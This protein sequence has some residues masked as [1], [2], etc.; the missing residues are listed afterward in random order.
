MFQDLHHYPREMKLIH[1]SVTVPTLPKAPG[2][3]EENCIVYRTVLCLQLA[4]PLTLHW[5]SNQL[6]TVLLSPQPPEK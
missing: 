2:T 3:V 1:D 5:L 4:S 6:L